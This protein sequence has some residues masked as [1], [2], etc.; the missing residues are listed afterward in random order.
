MGQ[1]VDSRATKQSCIKASVKA[2]CPRV[3]LAVVLAWHG[4]W[5]PTCH[6]KGVRASVR[7]HVVWTAPWSEM[8]TARASEQVVEGG[9]SS[10]EAE[11]CRARRRLVVRGTNLSEKVCLVGDLLRKLPTSRK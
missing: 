9:D 10:C 4:N 5:R 7:H 1:R 2:G 11:T 6:S 3:P 8:E